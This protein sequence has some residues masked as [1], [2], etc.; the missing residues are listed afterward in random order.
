MAVDNGALRL[1]PLINP[2]WG[3]QGIAYGPYRRTNGLALAVFLLNGHNASGIN[4]IEHLKNR[5]QRWW[6]GSET[7]PPRERMQRWV[8]SSHWRRM[9]RRLLGWMRSSPEFAKHFQARSLPKLDENLAVGWF[10]QA[11]PK[12]PRTEGHGLIMH[13]SKAHNGELW[14]RTGGNLLSAIPNVQN[15]PLYCIVI[16]R[17][18]GAAY[19]VASVAGAQ[20]FGVY[21]DMRPI[22]IDPSG[23]EATLYAAVYQSVLGQIGF[24]VDTR[25]YG[26]QVIQVPEFDQWFGTA[27]GADCL[28]GTGALENRD[29]DIGGQWHRQGGQYR[30]TAQGSIALAAGSGAVLNLKQPSGLIHLLVTTADRVTGAALRWRVQDDDNF[31]QFRVDGEWSKLQLYTKGQWRTVAVSALWHLQP[32]QTHSLQILDEGTTFRLYLDGELVF[33]KAFHHSQLRAA[34][35]V[36]IGA[37]D[38]NA[39]LYLRA[40]EAHPRSVPIPSGLD[41]G[42][43]WA[44]QGSH[45]AIADTFSGPAG[46][47]HGQSTPTGQRIWQ[48][49][50]GRGTFELTGHDSLQVRADAQTPNPGRTAY[51]VPWKQPHLAD[52]EITIT[53]PGTGRWQRQKG[54]GGLIFWQ[55]PENYIVINNWLDDVYSG[56]SI[57]SFFHLNGFEELYD[58]VWTNVH[59]RVFWGTAHRLRAV[60][61]GLH[62]TVFVNDEPVLYRALTDVYADAIRLQIRQ[63]GIVANWEWGNDTGSIFK[64][65]VARA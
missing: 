51:T 13:G 37:S 40:L 35:G 24:R 1:Q 6:V 19:Y 47:L 12:D 59:H 3:K 34:T 7:C 14:T 50:L 55:D 10:S 2:G 62:Y 17:T 38:P 31:W 49:T 57:S 56:A 48:R 23:T 21:P 25:V 53:P 65:F 8:F 28:T 20:G 52:L 33:G 60:F 18:Q 43:P 22:A 58:A 54:R 36:G 45:V 64:D 15:L 32:H 5:L 4:T 44:A 39:T 61:D 9:G 46:D 11:V 41:L 27:H 63:V 30:R 16:L 26:T 29:A 42:A